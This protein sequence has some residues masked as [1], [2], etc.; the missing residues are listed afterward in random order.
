MVLITPQLIALPC[1]AQEALLLMNRGCDQGGCPTAKRWS[2]HHD[3]R[4]SSED[5]SRHVTSM[6]QRTSH[7]VR[8]PTCAVPP[9]ISENVVLHHNAS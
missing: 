5:R 3:T 6:Q 1:G 9:S 2:A 4:L 8:H 7:L